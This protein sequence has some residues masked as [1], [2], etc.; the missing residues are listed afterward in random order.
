MSRHIKLAT[1]YVQATGDA[2]VHAPVADAAAAVQTTTGRAAGRKQL[3]KSS[4]QKHILM[5]GQLRSNAASLQTG[6]QGNLLAAQAGDC[7]M[8]QGCRLLW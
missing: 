7:L 8:S 6:L 4:Q 5:T 1:D 2:R 3:A